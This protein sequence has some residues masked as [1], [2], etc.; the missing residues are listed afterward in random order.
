M[1]DRHPKIEVVAPFPI[2]E[3]QAEDDWQKNCAD[4]PNAP[5]KYLGFLTTT[6]IQEQIRGCP[7]P[8]LLMRTP[9]IE[10]FGKVPFELN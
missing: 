6:H 4:Y 10:A 9:W 1:H 5:V 3:I 7:C 8:P 2:M